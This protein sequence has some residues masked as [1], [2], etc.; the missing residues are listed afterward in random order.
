MSA[1]MQFLTKLQARKEPLRVSKNRNQADIAEFRLRMEQLQEQISGWLAGTGVTPEL[2]DVLLS[3]LL[4]EGR[5]LRCRVFRC[6][7]KTG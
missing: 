5:V 1:K 2:S 3:D 6:V 7:M 4:V